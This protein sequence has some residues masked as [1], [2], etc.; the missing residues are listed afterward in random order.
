MEHNAVVDAQF[1]PQARAYLDSPVHA[2]GEDLQALAASAKALA[3]QSVLDVG[4]GAGHAAFAVAP[5]AGRVTASD[6]SLEMLR[7]VAK[8]AADRGIENLFTQ[9]ASARELP[10]EDASFDMVVT[11]YSA[12]H[13]DDFEAGL[14]EIRRVI[15]PGGR[16][17][18]IDIVAPRNTVADTFLQSIELLRDPSHVRNYSVAQW[19]AALD[20]AGFTPTGQS[21]RR[22]RLEYS[23]W[24]ARM[25]TPS[26][27]ATAIRALQAAVGEE[28]RRY[29][30]IGAQG[31]FTPDAATFE[32]RA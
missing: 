18:A 7:V 1:G 2:Q 26:E 22:V 5:H 27:H 10:F 28:V 13:W 23:S 29:F 24:I 25:R 21:M 8:A 14:R 6:L 12:H 30:E 31:C 17:V 15:K 9:Q 32:A 20:R 4:C 11:R 16:F 3:P 19:L